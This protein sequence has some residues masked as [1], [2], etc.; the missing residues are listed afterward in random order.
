M[1]AASGSV[2][3]CACV[4]VCVCRGEYQGTIVGS[5]S[6]PLSHQV[7]SVDDY[8]VTC[9]LYFRV[10]LICWAPDQPYFVAF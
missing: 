10:Y 8:Y 9:D 6:S 1:S 2:A 7:R 3:V 5:T 4:C